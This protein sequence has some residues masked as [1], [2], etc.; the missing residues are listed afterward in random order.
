MAAF[1]EAQG[2]LPG[3]G[4]R[5]ARSHGF[6][7]ATLRVTQ[8]LET[9]LPGQ[10]RAERRSGHLAEWYRIWYHSHVAAEDP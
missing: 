1:D 8:L 6:A 3:I 10:F 5:L 4:P 7:S 9:P 2:S